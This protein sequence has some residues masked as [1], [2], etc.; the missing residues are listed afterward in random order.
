MA[1]VYSGIKVDR[2]AVFWKYDGR[3]AYCGCEL[4]PDHFEVDH[5]VPVKECGFDN[6]I[7][8]LNPSCFLCNNFKRDKSIEV[9]RAQ[10]MQIHRYINGYYL[11]KIATKYGLADIQEFDGMFYYEKCAVEQII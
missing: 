2:K 3:C 9:F 8:N 5:I 10:L 4:E 6:R 7:D 11:V 1:N